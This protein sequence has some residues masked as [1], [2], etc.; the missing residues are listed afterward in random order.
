MRRRGG[1]PRESEQSDSGGEGRGPSED[2]ATSEASAARLARPPLSRSTARASAARRL[3]TQK[4]VELQQLSRSERPSER[5]E[6]GKRSSLAATTS[7]LWLVRSPL[8]L[9]PLNR[10]RV[11]GG[12]DARPAPSRHRRRPADRPLRE[13]ADSESA[14]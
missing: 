6:Q 9:K 7:R 10:A 8:L 12:T 11:Q 5:G 1:E 14:G 3:S 13:L 2:L 4:E